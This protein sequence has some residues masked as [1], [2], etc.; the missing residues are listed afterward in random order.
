MGT[1]GQIAAFATRTRYRPCPSSP[2][3]GPCR[4]RRKS[5]SLPDNTTARSP[6][7]WASRPLRRDQRVEHRGIERVHFVRPHQPDVGDTI[8]HRDLDA[9]IHEF[10]LLFF[11][12]AALQKGCPDLVNQP[13]KQTILQGGKQMFNEQL[14]AGRRIL[15][16]GGGTGL[17]KIDGRTLPRAWRRGSYLRPPKGRLRRNR[18]RIDGPLWRQGDEPGVDIRNPLAVVR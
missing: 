10:S 17:G 13:I 15:V 14:L 1:R 18:D 7:S 2:Q 3:T 6:F 12:V 9:F 4:G 11:V 5:P 8:R 16:T